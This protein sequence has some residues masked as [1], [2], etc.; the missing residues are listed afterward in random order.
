MGYLYTRPQK[1]RASQE[2][3]FS[4]TLACVLGQKRLRRPKK[5]LRQRMQIL[6]IRNQID[7]QDGSEGNGWASTEFALLPMRCSLQ[8]SIESYRLNINITDPRNVLKKNQ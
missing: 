2:Y 4:D 7:V 3:V 1:L 5:L 8:I 6:A